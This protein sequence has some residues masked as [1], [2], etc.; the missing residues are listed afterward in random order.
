MSIPKIIHYCWLSDDPVPEDMKRYTE[1]WRQILPDYEFVKWDLTKFEKDSSVWVSEA[2]DRKKYAF[3]SDYIRVYAIYHY[4]GIYLDMDVEVL[5]PFDELLD[6]PYMFAYE[7]PDKNWIE[8]GCFG[9]EK[10]DPFLKACLDYYENRHF[11]CADGFLDTV[12]QPI[13]M[14]DV[15]RKRNMS[16]RIYPWEY[17]TA[18]SLATG[19]ETP[20]SNT[21]AV[22]HFTNS[23]K[24]EEERRIIEKA[25]GI[26]KA[27]PIIGK[28]PAFV[29]D[30]TH[31]A[32]LFLQTGGVKELRHRIMRYIREALKEAG[33]I[34]NE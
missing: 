31:K 34:K 16:L 10:H 5:K 7:R 13:I 21:F 30:K 6:S 19:I 32:I 1:G 3:A 15:L 22:H 29:Y 25:R 33:L 18:K 8:A 11:V 17:F 28:Y 14:G 2:F 20:C 23:W 27:H 4:G 24:S 9:A 12:P 26:R